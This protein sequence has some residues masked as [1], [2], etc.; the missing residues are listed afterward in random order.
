MTLEGTNHSRTFFL[1]QQDDER[2]TDKCGNP[3]VYD[4]T[5]EDISLSVSESLESFHYL[6]SCQENCKICELT[7]LLTLT[8]VPL[9]PG[10]QWPACK[11]LLR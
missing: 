7:L 11:D 10:N 3:H 2:R 8:L 4:G 1:Y 9:G 5:I 6:T